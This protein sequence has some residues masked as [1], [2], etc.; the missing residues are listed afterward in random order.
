MTIVRVGGADKDRLLNILRNFIAYNDSN[1]GNGYVLE[2]S[3]NAD[4]DHALKVRPNAAIWSEPLGEV[5][6]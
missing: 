6:A 2:F 4:V 1:P 3:V 5:V